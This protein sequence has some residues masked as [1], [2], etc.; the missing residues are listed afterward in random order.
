MPEEKQIL[1]REEAERLL[2]VSGNVKGAII[3]ASLEYAIMKQG[4]PVVRAIEQRLKELGY[5]VNL[6]SIKPMEK[7][8]EALSV[9]IILLIREILNL[10]DEDIIEMG[11]AGLKLPYFA[12]MISK[13]FISIESVLN[14]AS[15]YWQRYFDFGK[16]EVSQYDKEKKYTILRVV[17]YN[18][19]PVL[20]LYH[21][22]YFIQAAVMATGRKKI[23]SKEIKCVHRGDP[24]HEY[25]LSWR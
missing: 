14:Q 19:H 4:R 1:T 6:Q 9:M 18:F 21:R 10:S 7:Y 13:Y 23:E 24:Y 5:P 20:C 15:K 17:G 25:F 11:R 16:M 3:L 12:K 8:P 2:A 22:G